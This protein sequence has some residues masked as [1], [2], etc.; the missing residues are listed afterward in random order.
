MLSKRHAAFC[1][2]LR[3]SVALLLCFSVAIPLCLSVAA[4]GTDPRVGLKPGF[5]DAGH[6]ASNVELIGSAPRPEGFFDPSAPA[7][8]PWPAEEPE[9]KKEEAD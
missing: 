7:G 2:F 3:F 9:K 5:K 6:A 8:T 4:Q 1:V